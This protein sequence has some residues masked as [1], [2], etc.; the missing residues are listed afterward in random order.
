MLRQKTYG[1][2]G[3]DVLTSIAVRWDGSFVTAGRTDSN[4]GDITGNHGK[5]DAWVLSVKP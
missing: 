3:I 1:G 4:D 5:S 2:S